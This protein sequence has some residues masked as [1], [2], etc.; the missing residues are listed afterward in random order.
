MTSS[1]PLIL[2]R[3][4]DEK[5]EETSERGERSGG[6]RSRGAKSMVG[7][8]SEEQDVLPKSWEQ[9]M[10]KRDPIWQGEDDNETSP[11][12]RDEG[13]EPEGVDDEPVLAGPWDLK[14]LNQFD[15]EL[16]T[17]LH[18]PLASQEKLKQTSFKE[19]LPLIKENKDN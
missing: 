15:T 16:W 11:L 17:P 12:L 9:F 4:L 18:A 1:A 6:A 10:G 5:M 13:V 7:R 14:S 3:I 8:G 2:R 19:V